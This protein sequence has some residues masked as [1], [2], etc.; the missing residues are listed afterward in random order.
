MNERVCVGTEIEKLEEAEV[1][2]RAGARTPRTL[3]AQ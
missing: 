2:K 3:P 1:A